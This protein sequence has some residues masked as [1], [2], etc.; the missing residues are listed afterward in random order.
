M[1]LMVFTDLFWLSNIERFFL[2]FVLLEDYKVYK[3][4]NK[5]REKSYI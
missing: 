3:K 4:L 2:G 1:T 5:N